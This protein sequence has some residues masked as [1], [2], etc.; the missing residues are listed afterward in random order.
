[1]VGFGEHLQKE[2]TDTY[3]GQY[4]DYDMLKRYQNSFSKEYV[5]ACEQ[6]DY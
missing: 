1:M 5:S 4:L 2:Q 3:E 6:N